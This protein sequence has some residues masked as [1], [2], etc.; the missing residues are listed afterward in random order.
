VRLPA[1]GFSG[2][3]HVRARLQ[4][5]QRFVLRHEGNVARVPHARKRMLYEKGILGQKRDAPP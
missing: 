5:L 4:H 1:P 2:E 3:E